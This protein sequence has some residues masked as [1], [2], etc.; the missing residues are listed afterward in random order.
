MS[1]EKQ[2]LAIMEKISARLKPLNT[3]KTAIP[4]IFPAHMAAHPEAYTFGISLSN[5]IGLSQKQR[6]EP[7]ALA[8]KHPSFSRSFP[9]LLHNQPF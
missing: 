7:G 9:R 1:T 6:N 4:T 3:D 8:V 2:E 5:P